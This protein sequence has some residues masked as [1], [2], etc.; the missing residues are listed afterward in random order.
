MQVNQI[1]DNMPEFIGLFVMAV[2]LA[3]RPEA[4]LTAAALDTE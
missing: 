2:A 3:G 1:R 4:V